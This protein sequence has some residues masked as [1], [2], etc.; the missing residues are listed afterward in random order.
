[1]LEMDLQDWLSEEHFPPLSSRRQIKSVAFGLPKHSQPD[2]PIRAERLQHMHMPPIA[3]VDSNTI[4]VANLPLSFNWNSK[5]SG[6]R[7]PKTI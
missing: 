1:M 6:V 2:E 4:V 5:G 3:A 7:N